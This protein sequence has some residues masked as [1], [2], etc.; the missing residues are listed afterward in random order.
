MTLL[1]TTTTPNGNVIELHEE[2]GHYLTRLYVMENELELS[3]DQAQ[4]WYRTARQAGGKLNHRFPLKARA[5]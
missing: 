4:D 1:A 2:D 3:E 5:S